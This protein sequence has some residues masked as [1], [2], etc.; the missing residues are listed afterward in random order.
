[1]D[2][3]QRLF[4]A[5]FSSRMKISL[6]ANDSRSSKGTGCATRP[7]RKGQGKPPKRAR[8]PAKKHPRDFDPFVTSSHGDGR[9]RQHRQEPTGCMVGVTGAAGGIGDD[10]PPRS[11]GGGPPP[12][13][14]SGESTPCRFPLT[15]GFRCG[16]MDNDDNMGI[17]EAASASG[18]GHAPPGGGPPG[19]RRPGGPTGGG[20]HLEDRRE[21]DHLEGHQAEDHQ[22]EDPLADQ[23]A[24]TPPINRS[25]QTFPR[26]LGDGSYP[27]RGRS[28]TWS[29]RCRSPR[30][31]STGVPPSPPRPRES[32][33]W[34]STRPGR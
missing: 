25:E 26:V 31:R 1:M 16:D 27:S 15:F 3:L 23:Q 7:R 22:A 6:N 12:P 10:T 24:G 8:R 28:G 20:D 18:I 11:D 30:S 13:Y 2:S 34:P 4:E 9:V 5:D 14:R 17:T 33:T 32:W 21:E 29:A 19:G